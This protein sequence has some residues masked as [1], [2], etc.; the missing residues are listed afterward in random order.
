MTAAAAEIAEAAAEHLE[1]ARRNRREVPRSARAPLLSAVIADRF[2]GRLKRASYNPFAP[3]LAA[4]DTL[5]SWQLFAAAL[6]GRF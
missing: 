3:E 6:R 4:P 2:L 1:A 5:Q